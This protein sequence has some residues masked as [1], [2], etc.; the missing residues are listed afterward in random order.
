M[1]YV[2]FAIISFVV[3]MILFVI[4]SCIVANRID[5]IIEEETNDNRR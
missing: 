5:K 4:S 2:I 1:K 3:L